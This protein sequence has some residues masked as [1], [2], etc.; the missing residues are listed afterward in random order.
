MAKYAGILSASGL[1]LATILSSPNAH[2]L[3]FTNGPG[4]GTI[5]LDVHGG[6]TANGTPVG[7][8]ACNLT[9]SQVWQWVGLQVAGIGSSVAGG[10]CLD[11]EGSGTANGSRIVL[12]DC[13]G[14]G[15]QKWRYFDFQIINT[16][17][18][19]CLDVG[20]GT[21]PVQATI[22]TCNGSLGQ[23]WNIR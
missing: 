7:S 12:F 8:A 20:T 15:G 2:A 10:K 9:F 18:N 11:V 19:K 4:N 14:T 22:Q 16:H 23:Q 1:L 5:C 21:L 17:S 3:T 13:N 6:N